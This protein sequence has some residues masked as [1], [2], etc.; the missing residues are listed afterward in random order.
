MREK[1]IG[2]DHPDYAGSLNNLAILYSDMG[3]YQKAEPFF[4]E[5]KAIRGKSPW[6][7][8]SRICK[9]PE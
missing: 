4:L 3:N 1:A 6:Q 8:A 7:G 9:K 2:K 5:A